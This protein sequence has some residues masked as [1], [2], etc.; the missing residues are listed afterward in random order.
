MELLIRAISNSLGGFELYG[1]RLR[2]LA[3]VDDLVLIADSPESLQ[4]MLN[5]T[6]QAAD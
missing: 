3:Y 4:C 5:V 1:N 2:I 6:S